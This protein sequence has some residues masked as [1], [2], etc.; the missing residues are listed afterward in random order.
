MCIR[1]RLNPVP[2]EL[3]G[4]GIVDVAKDMQAYID[5]LDEAI[6]R[7]CLICAQ[8]RYFFSENSGV[9]EDEFLSLI[10]ILFFVRKFSQFAEIVSGLNL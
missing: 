2:G 9:N 6:N 1:D 5:R 8:D 3:T 7:K 4:L 10:H